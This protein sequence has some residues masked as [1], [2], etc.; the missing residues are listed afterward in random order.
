M[1]HF[2]TA[3]VIVYTA[4]S[5]VV[6]L[7]IV[8]LQVVLG[9]SRVQI[10]PALIPILRSGP[11]SDAFALLQRALT[12]VGLIG[13]VL[14]RGHPIMQRRLAPAQHSLSLAVHALSKTMGN[15]SAARLATDTTNDA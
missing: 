8:K 13:G 4:A 6:L 2:L 5:Y 7:R 14:Q 11:L 15:A 9:L 12:L 10:L 1:S 3:K